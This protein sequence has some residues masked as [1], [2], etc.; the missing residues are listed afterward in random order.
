MEGA[1]GVSNAKT[2]TFIS[3]LNAAQGSPIWTARFCKWHTLS[4]LR[5]EL[6]STV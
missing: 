4:S 1:M 2:T 3:L 5:A 6:Q